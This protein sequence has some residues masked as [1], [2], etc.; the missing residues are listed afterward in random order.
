MRATHKADTYGGKISLCAVK[1]DSQNTNMIFGL[2]VA[3]HRYPFGHPSYLHTGRQ[4]W[5]SAAQVSRV[6]GCREC[7][8]YDY[9]AGM[10]SCDRA[11]I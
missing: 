5:L 4:V 3:D 2:V 8:H 10:E 1:R 6:L 7:P 11:G 9:C